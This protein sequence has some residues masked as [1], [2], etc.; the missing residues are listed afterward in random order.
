[1]R[2]ET[3]AGSPGAEW[4][5]ETLAT[6]PSSD[7]PIPKGPT[8]LA[9]TLPLPSLLCPQDLCSQRAPQKAEGQAW[10]PEQDPWGPNGQ[11]KCQPHSPPIPPKGLSPS[12]LIPLQ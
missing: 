8:L 5:G 1:M 11:G 4:A 6:F 10:G 3:S 2:P 12:L 7:P 9:S